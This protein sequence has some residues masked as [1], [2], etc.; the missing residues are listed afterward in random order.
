MSFDVGKFFGDAGEKLW[1]EAG[2]LADTVIPGLTAAGASYAAD[3]LY[4]LAG[5]QK[6]Q[7][8]QGIQKILD[9]PPADPNS[10]GA[11]LSGIFSQAG[12]NAAL[13]SYGPYIIVGVLA[14]GV[15]AVVAFGRKS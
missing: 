11:Y 5:D 7:A 14:V 13:K 8:Q 10:F 15:V 12:S 6:K 4:G 9:S 2:K 3:A 1:D